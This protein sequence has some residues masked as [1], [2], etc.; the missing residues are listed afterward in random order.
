MLCSCLCLFL[1]LSSGV[2]GVPVGN[3]ME[4]AILKGKAVRTVGAQ[5]M[6][7]FLTKTG[8]PQFERFKKG[9]LGGDPNDPLIRKLTTKI[10]G[11]EHLFPGTKVARAYSDILF[12]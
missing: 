7:D 4:E 8:I 2:E 5:S 1:E 9:I 3:A 10:V 6:S 11:T 12:I